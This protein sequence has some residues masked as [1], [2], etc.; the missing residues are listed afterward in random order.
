MN[1]VL[2]QLARVEWV[3][4]YPDRKVHG[5]P[6]EP[7]TQNPGKSTISDLDLNALVAFGLRGKLDIDGHE[8][9]IDLHAGVFTIN[10]VSFRLPGD[11]GTFRRLH[12][13]FTRPTHLNQ[14]GGMVQTVTS[15]NLG[16]TQGEKR[17]ILNLF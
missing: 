1:D 3:A 12:F 2:A 7:S 14:N 6:G 13:S 8:A 9:V 16:Y 5:H 15:F 4:I 11:N 17:F 10:G